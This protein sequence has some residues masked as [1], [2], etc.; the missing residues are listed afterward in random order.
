MKNLSFL[1]CA[2]ALALAVTASTGC[3]SISTRSTTQFFDA[4]GNELATR[5]EHTHS[6]GLFVKGE[7]VKIAGTLSFTNVIA[8]ADK[9]AILVGETKSF[10]ADKISS[11]ADAEAIKATGGA[12]GE[13]A[14][15][16]LK[17]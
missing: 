12:I 13:A 6:T 7:S 15:A 8:I 17:K 16:V 11:Q 4:Q 2:T 1:L 5:K 14:N 3:K 9:P 10:N